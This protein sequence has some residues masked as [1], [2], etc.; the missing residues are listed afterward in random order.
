[1]PLLFGGPDPSSALKQGEVLS[2]IWEH[3]PLGPACEHTEDTEIELESVPHSLVVVMTSECD[4]L[5][6]FAAR[7]PDDYPFPDGEMERRFRSSPQPYLLQHA[8]LCDAYEEREIRADMKSDIFRRVKQN[9]D[10]RY[11]HLGPA[12]IDGLDSE[13]LE[14]YLDFKA[15][16]SIPMD[17]VYSAVRDRP[18]MRKA[19]VPSYYVHDLIHRFYNFHSR[20]A[21]PE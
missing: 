11:H 13:E 6:D 4:L 7:F 18:T 16:F 8:L 5:H 20:V 17:A 19:V 12:G 14:I 1:M 3:R 10:K 21:V 2:N 15:A 9:Q